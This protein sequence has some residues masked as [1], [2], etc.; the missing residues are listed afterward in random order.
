MYFPSSLYIGECALFK[1]I[2][3]YY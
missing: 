2:N 3:S 1:E